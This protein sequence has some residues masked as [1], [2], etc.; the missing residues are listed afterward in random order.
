MKS[1]PHYVRCIKSNDM[2]KPE[3]YDDTRC[4]HQIQYLGLL[5]VS[6]MSMFVNECVT[7]M[8][9]RSPYHDVHVESCGMMLIISSHCISSHLIEHQSSSCWFCL[10]S[11]I[12]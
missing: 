11:R 10:S 8:T 1:N 4:K 9:C 12:S 3:I 2:K 7:M 5:E 6:E